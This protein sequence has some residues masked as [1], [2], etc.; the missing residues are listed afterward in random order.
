M[1]L[2][3]CEFIATNRDRLGPMPDGLK[4]PAAGA[5]T[6]NIVLIHTI[7]E[8]QVQIFQPARLVLFW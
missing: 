6:L 4:Y 5:V 7:L 8:M 3:G 2:P 1:V